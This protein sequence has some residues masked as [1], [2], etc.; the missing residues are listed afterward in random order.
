MRHGKGD[1]ARKVRIGRGISYWLKRH[2]EYLPQMTPIH[3]PNVNDR[4]NQAIDE[5]GAVYVMEVTP[6]TERRSIA[7]HR[8]RAS[9]CVRLFRAA[10]PVNVIMKMMGHSDIGTTMKYAVAPEDDMEQAARKLD[11]R[12][13]L[14]PKRFRAWDLDD[15]EKTGEKRSAAPIASRAARP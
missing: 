2:L 15:E 5:C 12:P 7:P 11:L 4:F 1:K 14:R 9:F 13:E 8:L 3:M 10:V 6:C